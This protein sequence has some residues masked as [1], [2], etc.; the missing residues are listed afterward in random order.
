MKGEVEANAAGTLYASITTKIT[1]IQAVIRAT[2]DT[3]QGHVPS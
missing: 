3:P 1:A 2:G